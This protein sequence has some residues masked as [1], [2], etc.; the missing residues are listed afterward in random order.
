MS[1]VN[2]GL[3]HFFPVYPFV[4]IGVGLTA[5]RLW[6]SGRLARCLV[7]L[8]GLGLA[9]ETAWAF[10]NYIN[11]FGVLCGG[12]A[13]GFNL[14]SDSNLDWGQDL[15]ALA[16]WQQEHSDVPLYLDYFGRCEPA[17]YGIRYFRLQTVQEAGAVGPPSVVPDRPGVIAVSATDLHLALAADPPLP[18]IGLIKGQN[19]TAVLNGTIYLF[20]IDP[21][22]SD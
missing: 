11:F 18:W 7:L 8:I 17:V 21:K 22:H 13:A 6:A 9:V 12:P 3:R 2:I 14:L 16:A 5:S 10:P 4:F 15:P 20:R 19:P 1:N